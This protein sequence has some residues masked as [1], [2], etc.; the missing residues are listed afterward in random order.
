M[1]HVRRAMVED[2]DAILPLARRFHSESEFH[3]AYRFDDAKVE[4]LV[5]FAM[6]STDWLALVALNS[7]AIVGFSLFLATEMYFSREME[8]SDL[9]FYVDPTQRGSRAAFVMLEA[10]E[11]W[12]R[13]ARCRRISIAPNTGINHDAAGRFLQRFGYKCRAQVW[14]LELS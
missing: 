12:A 10:L 4:A 7:D 5:R 1:T 3:R 14:T 6:D 13:R 8:A 9:A 11:K 2:L